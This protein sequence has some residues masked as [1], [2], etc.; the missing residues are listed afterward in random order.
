M[1]HA[2]KK[3]LVLGGTSGIGLAT[4]RILAE[5]G[6]EVV[7]F[8]RSE[9]KIAAAVE[10][11]STLGKVSGE[12]LDVLAVAAVVPVHVHLRMGAWAHG[13]EL[14]ATLEQTTVRQP[15]RD[16]WRACGVVGW[17]CGRVARVGVWS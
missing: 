16:A 3:A 2:G 10:E 15:I 8:G 12:R 11:L 17:A 14:N 5:G 9:E 13:R 1:A 7:A 4:V 6:A